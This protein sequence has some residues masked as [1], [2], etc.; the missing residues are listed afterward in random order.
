MSWPF[1]FPW[2]EHF[3]SWVRSKNCFSVLVTRKR[4]KKRGHHEMGIRLVRAYDSA[5]T[6]V[7][8]HLPLT[9]GWL[10]RLLCSSGWCIW[11]WYFSL[12]SCAIKQYWPHTLPLPFSSFFP[13][14]SARKIQYTGSGFY[15]DYFLP[16]FYYL[17]HN[18]KYFTQHFL[19]L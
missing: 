2:R 4:F 6:I 1:C 11:D 9:L 12:T 13:A 8:K 7:Q 18:T 19:I 5:T 10:C 15:K 14:S 3:N 16:I 17:C